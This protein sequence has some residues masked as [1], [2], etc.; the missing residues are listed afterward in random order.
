MKYPKF[1]VCVDCI[2]FNHA[3][4]INDTMNGFTIQQTS[5]PFVCT[6]VDDAST[7]GEQEIIKKY[8]DDNFDSSG[9]SLFLNKETDYAHIFFAQHKLNKNCFFAVLLLK[10]NH[11]SQNKSKLPYLEEWRN[12][13]DYIAICEGDDYWIDALKLQKQVSFMDDN[14]IY[15]LCYSKS[16]VVYE[17]ISQGNN[18]S[19]GRRI[20]DFESI[21]LKG[22]HIPSL[23]TLF[24][25]DLYYLYLNE[26]NPYA[27]DWLLGDYPLWIWFFKNS[28]VYF[29]D[30]ITAV[31][32]ILRESASHSADINK[33]LKFLSSVND[34]RLFYA[35]HYKKYQYLIP[36]LNEIYYRDTLRIGEAFHSQDCCINALEGIKNKNYKEFIKSFVY[37][38]KLLFSLKVKC[39]GV[40][41]HICRLMRTV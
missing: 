10:E 41:N 19:V 40:L 26:I 22:N 36:S 4:F 20:S 11:H 18:N 32:R 14:L 7:D 25:K 21:M 31:Y 8:I 39:S 27:K 23:T 37:R 12:D 13:I 34:I 9:G 5:F 30:E 33:N 15:G 3:K 35:N 38:Y 28:K 6:I 24:R 29:F 1:K 16:K 2:T 17:S